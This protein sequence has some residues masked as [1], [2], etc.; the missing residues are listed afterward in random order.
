[1]KDFYFSNEDD[2]KDFLKNKKWLI[3]SLIV[4]GVKKSFEENLD[5]I[6]V[7][8]IINPISNFVM[9]S[10]IKKEDWLDSLSKSMEYYESVEEYEKCNEIKE[11]IKNIKDDFDRSDKGEE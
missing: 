10:E 6:V 4:D 5:S 1:M 11:L 3:H 2:E 9:T 8:R 7:F